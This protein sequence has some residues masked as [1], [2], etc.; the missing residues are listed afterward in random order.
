MGEAFGQRPSQLLSGELSDLLLD[1]VLYSHVCR[2]RYRRARRAG[3][4]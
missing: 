4:A 3:S 1:L 2:R